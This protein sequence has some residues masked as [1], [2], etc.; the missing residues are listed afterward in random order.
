[1]SEEQ[2]NIR[3][4]ILFWEKRRI[5]YN[6]LLL[7]LG[8]LTAVEW[9]KVTNANWW[10]G[11]PLSIVEVT[12]ICFLFGAMANVCYSLAPLVD[13]YHTVLKKKSI[14]RTGINILFFLGLFFSIGI[15][16]AIGMWAG[17]MQVLA[18]V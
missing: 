8:I 9:H 12:I 10:H 6:V 14:S 11:L 3:F 13:I 18:G 15:E 4:R 5:V 1:M 7:P 16:L 2:N 17:M